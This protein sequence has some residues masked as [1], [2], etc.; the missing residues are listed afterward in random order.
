MSKLNPFLRTSF[1]ALTAALAQP[2]LAQSTTAE[3]AD[4]GATDMGDIVVTAQ[5]REQSVNRVPLAITA[6]EGG[7][8]LSQGVVG[9]KDLN[10]IAP[11]LQI[12]TVGSNSFVGLS[13]RGIS[14]ASYA[15]NANPAVSTYIDGVYVDMPAG[16]ANVMYDLQRIEVL[17][18]PQGTLYGRNATG[19]NLNIVTADPKFEFGG[20]ADL[21]Y[22]SF[23]DVLAH[24]AVNVPVS[25]TLAVRFSGFMHR[26]DGMFDT[27]GTTARNYGA[28]DDFGGRATLLWKPSPSLTWR[29]SYD[30]FAMRGTPGLSIATNDAVKPVNGLP[31]FEQPTTGDPEPLTRLQSHTIRSRLDWEFA[32]HLTLSYIAGYQRLKMHYAW[33]SAGEIPSDRAPSYQQELAYKSESTSHEINL[34]FS[35]SWLTNVAGATYFRNDIPYL[36]VASRYPITG[37]FSLQAAN[38]GISKESWGIFN[39]STVSVTDALRITAGLRYSDDWQSIAAAT[40]VS[41]SLAANPTI[42]LHDVL[43]ITPQTTGCNAPTTSNFAE[44]TSSKVTW[45]AGVEYDLAPGTMGYATIATG[46]KQGGVQ[47]NA[48]LVFGR[49]F[50]PETVTN[51]EAGVKGRA[52]AGTLNYR[53]AG[54]YSDYKDLQVFQYIALGATSTTVT[55]NAGAARIYGLEL[56]AD[57]SPTPN[58]R[59]SSFLTYTN[60]RYTRFDNAVDSRTGAIVPS[61]AGNMLPLA[62]DWT[63]RIQYAHDFELA[64]GGRIT[65]Q[66]TFFTQSTSYTQAINAPAYRIRPFTRSDLNL[67]YVSPNENWTLSAYVFNLENHIIKNNDYSGTNLVFSD[68]Q[69]PRTWGVRV[70][71]KY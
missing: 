34:S 2:A 3:V 9:V 32:D 71:V 48:P 66:A 50:R 11:N 18:G 51:Y 27:Q 41:C 59:I 57:W 39:Q 64:N 28:A 70:A 35:N 12:R 55:S 24:A 47:P 30:G 44:E 33:A 26:S 23:D 38:D 13:I 54:F 5:K 25:D 52:F 7:K 20:S 14:N 63:F 10:S 17:R 4:Q 36:F 53:L 62:P 60:A 21:S 46:Y 43:S 37:R 49:T 58:D 15:L 31:I 42:R 61:L 22:G 19:G 69:P 68:F 67:T 1:L 16:L 29:L 65:P 45:R 6:V 56:E 40:T 8:L